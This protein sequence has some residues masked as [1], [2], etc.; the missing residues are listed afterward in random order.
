MA[1]DQAAVDALRK[2]VEALERRVKAVEGRA[3]TVY[4]IAADLKKEFKG[5]GDAVT[6]VQKGFSEVGKEFKGLQTQF[7]SV[8]STVK[9]L[10][11]PRDF[12]KLLKGRYAA[13]ASETTGGPGDGLSRLRD[14]FR[15]RP[16]EPT[17]AFHSPLPLAGGGRG[18]GCR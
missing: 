5:L 1:D 16:P 11:N 7:K 13:P 3:Q 12:K 15:I 18:R 4:G 14:L 2:Q 17:H 9:S 6:T 10:G 8:G